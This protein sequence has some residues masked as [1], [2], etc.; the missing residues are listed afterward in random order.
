[1]IVNGNL[2]IMTFKF[3]LLFNHVI[4]CFLS[5]QPFSRSPQSYT[6]STLRP[7]WSLA[8]DAAAAA[9]LNVGGHKN[10]IQPMNI[11]IPRDATAR[12][13]RTSVTEARHLAHTGAGATL[14]L[15]HG[16]QYDD[17]VRVPQDGTKH[18]DAARARAPPS[19]VARIRSIGA[20]VRVQSLGACL[21][22]NLTTNVRRRGKKRSEGA[23][24]VASGRSAKGRRKN[25]RCVSGYLY[26][27]PYL[28]AMLQKEKKKAG[29]SGAHWGK[30][31]LITESEYV[32][33]DCQRVNN[34]F[35]RPSLV[36]TPRLQSFTHGWWKNA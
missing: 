35:T 34:V 7:R 17:L 15:A 29:A 14:G 27:H 23:V 4:I 36:C 9:A 25:A 1:M 12:I 22:R 24:E 28:K 30:Y 10:M 20:V 5:L 13:P 19:R 6:T 3:K 33:P 16:R 11:L 31:G 26:K 2:E 18:V 32:R 21:N 8:E